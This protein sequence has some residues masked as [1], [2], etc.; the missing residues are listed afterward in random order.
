MSSASFLVLMN[1]TPTDFFQSSRGLR[2]G[3]PLSTYL[4]VMVMDA[5]SRLLV[6]AREGGF[7]SS[8][9]VGGRKLC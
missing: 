4:F 7:I 5:L 9:S 1:K 3:D 2:Q 8:F 6:K